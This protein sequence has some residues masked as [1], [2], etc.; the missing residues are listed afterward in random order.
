MN[1]AH[2]EVAKSIKDAVVNSGCRI[3][4][5]KTKGTL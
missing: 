2:V 5:V 1:R 3:K 4:A